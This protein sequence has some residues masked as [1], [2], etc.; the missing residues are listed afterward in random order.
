MSKLEGTPELAY[1][2]TTLHAHV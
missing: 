2:I 1:W